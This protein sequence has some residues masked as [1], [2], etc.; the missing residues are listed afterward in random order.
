MEKTF[1]FRNHFV[2]FKLFF[3]IRQLLEG[4]DPFAGDKISLLEA[5]GQIG[6]LYPSVLFIASD[7]QGIIARLL[8]NI[9]LYSLVFEKEKTKT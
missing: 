2:C 1:K 7:K 9:T 6:Y 8:V 3:F 5:S 4:S